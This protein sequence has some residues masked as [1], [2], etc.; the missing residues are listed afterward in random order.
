M[1]NKLLKIYIISHKKRLHNFANLLKKQGS[2]ILPNNFR[3]K[4]DE[5]N[6]IDAESLFAFCLFYG[7]E[8][9]DDES[10]WHYKENIIT[11]PTNIRF[12]IEKFHSLIFSETFLSDIHFSHFD[13]K[14]KVVVQAGGF[15]GDTALY[16]ASRGAIVYSFEPDINSYKLALE[17]IEL[18]P[19]FSK[20]IV[21][22]NYAIG[23]DAEIDFPINPKGSGGSSAYDLGNYEKIKVKSVSL[24]TILDEFSI[25]NPF[26]LDLDIKGKEFEII[27]DEAISKFEMARTANNTSIYLLLHLF[28]F[29]MKIGSF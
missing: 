21:M 15:I 12:K 17:N 6:K 16:Y 4:F 29:F 9:S 10:H 19:N 8:F 26:L 2:F 20:N 18:N 3:L 13:L 5:N 11:T 7:V 14:N 1:R 24:S 28:T 22:K 25:G 27:N 23:N